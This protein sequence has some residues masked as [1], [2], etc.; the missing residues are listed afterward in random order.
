MRLCVKPINVP[1]FSCLEAGGLARYLFDFHDSTM[2][3]SHEYQVDLYDCSLLPDCPQ[4]LSRFL[5]IADWMERPGVQS[6]LLNFHASGA[7]PVRS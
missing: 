2:G 1:Y 4:G 5:D 7:T 6:V 3:E